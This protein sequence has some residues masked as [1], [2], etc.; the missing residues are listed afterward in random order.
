MARHDGQRHQ[1]FILDQLAQVELSAQS[2]QILIAL[3]IQSFG[4]GFVCHKPEGTLHVQRD[5]DRG[6]AAL[7]FH[8]KAGVHRQ[9]K[10]DLPWTSCF[11]PDFGNRFPV[12]EQIRVQAFGLLRQALIFQERIMT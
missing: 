6:E 5:I 11:G 3:F 10:P 2:Q 4:R 8:G 12:H 7:A 1:Q 9:V